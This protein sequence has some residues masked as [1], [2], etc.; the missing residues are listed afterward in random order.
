M[1]KPTIVTMYFNLKE[2][3]DSSKDTRP[4]EFYLTNGRGTLQLEYPMVLFCDSV[5]RPLL[6]ALRDE[7]VDPDLYPTVYIERNLSDYDFYKQC[8]PLITENRKKS[9]YYKNKGDRNTV[10]YLLVCMFKML[11]VQIASER[12]DYGSSHYFWMD[13]GCSHVAKNNM[14]ESSIIMLENPNP[15][16]SV[17]YI[18]YRNKSELEDMENIVSSGT[19]GIAGTVFSAEKNYIIKFCSYMWSIFYE[20]IGRGVG[21]TDEQVFTYCYD[22]HPELFTIYFGDYYS[23]IR[24]Y[25]YVR[26]DWHLIQY[27][28]IQSSINAGRKDLA[29]LA[30]KS[31]LLGYEKKDS[32][33]PNSRLEYIRSILS[34]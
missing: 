22:R 2:L 19:C 8:W 10:S 1:V 26:Q 21:H 29:K 17:L 24:N 31:I 16:I 25:H 28:F 30:A 20:M 6:Q 23:V 14:K 18:H 3:A 13:F 11:A 33:F 32:D 4:I 9:Q 15:K 7:L 12:N 27:S 34:L 5:T